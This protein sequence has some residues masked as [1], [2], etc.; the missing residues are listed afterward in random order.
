[1]SSGVAWIDRRVSVLNGAREYL[2]NIGLMPRPAGGDRHAGRDRNDWRYRA[3]T[4]VGW[5]LPHWEGIF[6]DDMLID[7]AKERG[8][9]G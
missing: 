8:F 3:S 5:R 2:T 9:R 6:T 7:F 4:S 1:V